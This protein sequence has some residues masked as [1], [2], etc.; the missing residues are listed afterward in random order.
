MI[1]HPY[2]WIE[3]DRGALL[4]NVATFKS[5]IGRSSYLAPVIKSNA[6]GH[7]L[8]LIAQ[9]LD[10]NSDVDFF[11]VAYLS[12]ALQLREK[13]IQKPLLVMSCIDD[14]PLKAR[15]MNIHFIVGDM[16]KLSTL[17]AVG[18]KI[19]H[20]F[21]VHLKI[22]TGLSRFGVA[23]QE[24]IALM[25]TIKKMK[26]VRFSGLCTHFAE[27][28]KEDQSFTQQQVDCFLNVAYSLD[29]RPA[30]VHTSNTA[31]TITAP[32]SC[33][34]MFRI[35]LGIYGYWP[36]SFV[37]HTALMHQKNMVLKPVLSFKT[38]IMEI[39]LIKKGLTI[40][41]DRTFTTQRDT[42]I[43]LLPV[44]YNDGYDFRLCNNSFVYI[45]DRLFPLIGKVAMN[46]LI[47]DI[48]DSPSLLVGTEVLLLGDKPGVTAHDFCERIGEP[49]PRKI[50][51][52]LGAHVPRI[53]V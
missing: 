25:H 38:R 48:T 4:H 9:L 19:D 37:Q 35:G 51:T 41:Y 49:N 46:V 5:F 17:S 11:C 7:G 36:S 52:S 8:T 27:S 43:A 15:G 44:G 3:I 47:I 21:D 2:S 30:Y 50:T 53:V 24:A 39:K 32:V 14:D 23:A 1:I 31:G 28:Y 12:E 13:G 40:G 6:Y 10:N 26:G 45:N 18:Q 33:A 42:V 34:N 29:Q 16:Q 20:D 22:D